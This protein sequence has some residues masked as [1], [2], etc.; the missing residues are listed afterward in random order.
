VRRRRIVTSHGALL[1]RQR[2]VC[3]CCMQ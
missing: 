2:C 1:W 3:T